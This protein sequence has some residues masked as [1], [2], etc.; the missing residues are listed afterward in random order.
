MTTLHKAI[1]RILRN[2]LSDP[3]YRERWI[4]DL[5]NQGCVSGM[6]AG[7]TSYSDTTTFFDEYEDEILDLAKEYEFTAD[8]ME[9]GMTGF[10]NIIA[11]FAFE[12]LARSVFETMDF[13]ELPNGDFVATLTGKGE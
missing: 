1:E 13:G 11:W 12:T 7:L 5:E 3:D 9:L 2:E 10:K 6:V 4:D 8:I